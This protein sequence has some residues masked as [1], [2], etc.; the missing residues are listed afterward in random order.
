MGLEQFQPANGS[1]PLVNFYI[2][3]VN[4]AI[5]LHH[6]MGRNFLNLKVYDKNGDLLTITDNAGRIIIDN[7]VT[8]YFVDVGNNKK[9]TINLTS[10]VG[11][12]KTELFTII[13]PICFMAN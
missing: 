6:L 7:V 5:L 8:S 3:Q 9:C 4:R 2:N 13:N 12:S 10:D 11:I 1:V